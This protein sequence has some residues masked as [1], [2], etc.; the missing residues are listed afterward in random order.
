MSWLVSLYTLSTVK[1]CLKPFF[2]FLLIDLNPES[3]VLGEK[4]RKGKSWE[5]KIANCVCHNFHPCFEALFQSRFWHFAA[6]RH[7]FSTWSIFRLS[8]EEQS[9]K[10][11]Y[12]TVFE[13]FLGHCFWWQICEYASEWV[14]QNLMRDFAPHW[15][16]GGLRTPACFQ[17]V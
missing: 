15:G 7:N 8:V 9:E 10:D 12:K 11:V 17:S 3:Q 2:F 16:L 5:K 6:Q 13:C 4:N 1:A 14:F